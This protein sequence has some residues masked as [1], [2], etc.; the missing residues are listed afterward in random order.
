[1]SGGL[2]ILVADAELVCKFRCNAAEQGE[3]SFFRGRLLEGVTGDEAHQVLGTAYKGAFDFLG[4]EEVPDRGGRREVLRP[5][6]F[7][8]GFPGATRMTKGRMRIF[9]CC[10]A[11]RA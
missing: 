8:D 3:E 6:G 10:D 4:V 7:T 5:E 11:L 1:M 9:Q 2:R